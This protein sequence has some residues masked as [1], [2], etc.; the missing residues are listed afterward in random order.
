MHLVVEGINEELKSSG[1]K[2]EKGL[3]ELNLMG[4]I[5]KNGKEINTRNCTLDLNCFIGLLEWMG[6]F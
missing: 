4:C 3:I 1:S 6:F 5:D 2:I